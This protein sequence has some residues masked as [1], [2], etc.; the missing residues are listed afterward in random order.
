MADKIN[1]VDVLII[2]GGPAGLS[3][4]LHLARQSHSV[5]IFDSGSY[6][7]DPSAELHGVSTWDHQHPVDFR[8]KSREELGQFPNVRIVDI[9]VQKVAKINEQLF[10]IQAEN[11]KFWI[12]K[13]VLLATGSQEI[14]PEIDGYNECWG[15]RI[16]HC[17][18]A[19]NYK[20]RKSA[21]AGVLAVK[22]C[23]NL[24]MALYLAQKAAQFSAEVI[25][26]THGDQQL[27]TQLEAA[28]AEAA[29]QTGG[30]NDANQQ[31]S[32][33]FKVVSDP[34]DGIVT[35]YDADGNPIA[36]EL[37]FVD[38]TEEIAF[39]LHNPIV[40]LRGTFAAQLGVEVAPGPF[41]GTGN[42]SISA[43][44]LQTNV[45]GVFAAGDCMANPKTIP[46]AMA[47]GCNAAI[48]ISAQLLAEKHHHGPL[49]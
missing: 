22:P 5:T 44:S 32:K 27:A 46:N 24:S 4:A 18:F 33:L 15:R 43:P 29:L 45:R 6:R 2:G 16:F 13:K 8:N 19:D 36:L 47:T 41:P 14:F 3:A 10:C 20:V 39:M 7:N 23:G 34:V 17:L 48:G 35:V 37:Y 42:I 31:T 26:Y 11:D 49:F 38:R 25:I 30:N 40:V 9:E 28:L 1:P 12:G 21:A